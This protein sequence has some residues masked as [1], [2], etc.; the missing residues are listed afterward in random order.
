MNNILKLIEENDKLIYESQ[1]EMIEWQAACYME[2]L[3]LEQMMYEDF[4]EEKIEY[5]IEGTMKERFANGLIKLREIVD[6]ALSW[7]DTFIIK[8]E[9][10]VNLYNRL[11]NKLGRRNIDNALRESNIKIKGLVIKGAGN[12]LNPLKDMTDLAYDVFNLK[13]N[14]SPL[15]DNFKEKIFKEIGVKSLEDLKEV[16]KRSFFESDEPVEQNVR[17]IPPHIIIG[18]LEGQSFHREFKDLKN[19]KRAFSTASFKFKIKDDK[20]ANDSQLLVTNCT[21]MVNLLRTVISNSMLYYFK[22]ANMCK[23][24][25]LRV[26]G[27]VDGN[28]VKPDNDD[29]KNYWD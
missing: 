9:E 29:E 21:F 17:D 22:A 19:I 20:T 3:V 23:S 18:W 11:F 8:C 16:I 4:D 6:K 5:M 13:G 26:V 27:K 25:I 2:D 10:K 12:S 14:I 7:I 1:N 28:G 24:I 15:E